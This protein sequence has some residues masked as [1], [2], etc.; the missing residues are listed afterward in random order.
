M[1][2]EKYQNGNCLVNLSNSILKR[3]KVNTFHPSIKKIDDL[4][5][6]HKK[7][8]LFLFD[9]MGKNV[10]DLHNLESKD[11]NK[12][13]FTTIT[14]INP[15]TTVAATTALLSGKWPCETGWLGWSLPFYDLKRIIN[16]FQN[17]DSITDE[18]I[19]GPNI[20]E[21]RAGYSN[22]IE[23]INKQNH[24]EIAFQIKEYPIDLDG[25]KTL[26]ELFCLV[27]NKFKE[28]D[29][30]F[31]YA[32]YTNP[33]H[34]AHE[35]GIDS[36]EVK[37]HVKNINDGLVKFAKEN[38]DLL[39]LVI[40]DHGHINVTNKYLSDYPDIVD[41][42]QHPIC[43]E[44]RCASFKIK[45][46]KHN[47]FKFLFKKYFGDDFELFTKNQIIKNKLFGDAELSPLA[48]SFIGDYV[49]V[50]INDV[51]LINK[52][53]PHVFKGHH[54]GGTK[55]ELYINVIA[56]NKGDTNEI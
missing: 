37:N 53:E 6:N 33:D 35:F 20:M 18:V 12:N 5:I 4:L 34:D 42:L 1:N 8:A 32:Y 21:K 55:D 30:G 43:I 56:F 7:I 23:L 29:E 44:G 13:V 40:A 28:L 49:A 51:I 19:P 46:G 9:G 15:P 36:K 48:Y 50:A 47:Q 24:K 25:P 16:V 27:S 11:L 2:M 22:I 14:S 17:V 52:Y 54:A 41:L 45:H 3:F 26:A 38:P 10:L 39:V 31:V